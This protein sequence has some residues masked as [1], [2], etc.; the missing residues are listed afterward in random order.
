MIMVILLCDENKVSTG[1]CLS[2]N[3]IFYILIFFVWF[4]FSGYTSHYSGVNE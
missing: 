1:I 4:Q 2:P 3:N